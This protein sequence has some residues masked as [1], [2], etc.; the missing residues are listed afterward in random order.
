MIETIIAAGCAYLGL[1][2]A[3][4]CQR[5]RRILIA[6]SPTS[7]LRRA[8]WFVPAALLLLSLLLFIRGQGPA[9][10]ILLLLETA[11]LVCWAVTLTVRQPRRAFR[12]LQ[13]LVSDRPGGIAPSVP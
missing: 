11:P 4:L 8:A 1:L 5:S 7:E 12:L 10:G 2:I 6:R 13:P 9:F 3:S